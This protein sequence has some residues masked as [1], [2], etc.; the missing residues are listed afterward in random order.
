MNKR[1]APPKAKTPPPAQSRNPVTLNRRLT[2]QTR[3][4]LGKHYR[5][6]FGVK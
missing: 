5:A 1:S 6:K 4:V 3:R 2:Q